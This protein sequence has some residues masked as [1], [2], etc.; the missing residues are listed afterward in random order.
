MTE[1]DQ[2]SYYCDGLKR[3]TQAYVKLQNTMTLSEAMDQAVKYAMSHFGGDHKTNREKPEREQRFCGKPR[4]NHS[5]D[6]KSFSK[7]SFKPGHYAPTEQRKEEPVCYYCKKTG[8]FKCDCKKLKGEQENDQPRRRTSATETSTPSG[9]IS[10]ANG[11]G[12]HDAVDSESAT[13]KSRDSCRAVVSE[14]QSGCDVVAAERP[15]GGVKNLSRRERKD[16]QVEA[17]F[18]HGVVDSEGVE[19]KYITRKKLRK[20]L[21]LPAKDRPEHAFRIVLTNDTNQEIDRNIKRNDEPDNVGSEK[22]KRCLQ[23]DW[24]S[25]KTNPELPVLKY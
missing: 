14:T 22:A 7:R 24:D 19:T 4:A 16:T 13:T 6:K 2:V 12:L 11:S 1:V 9:K 20:F 18:T 25:F 23:T 10:Q 21:R 5:Q 8:H 3:A 15:A 17:M